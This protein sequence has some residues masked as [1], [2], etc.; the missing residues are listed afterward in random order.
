MINFSRKV[1]N[2]NVQVCF[3]EDGDEV[4][5]VTDFRNLGYQYL[6]Y[7]GE[8]FFICQ[9][10]GVTDR[11]NDPVRGRK[12]KYCKECA[13]KVASRQTAECVLRKR[14]KRKAAG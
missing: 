8:P 7:H 9:N 13:A 6:K 4:M 1:D 10:C 12:K 11:Y 14:E 2:T 3:A 5:R